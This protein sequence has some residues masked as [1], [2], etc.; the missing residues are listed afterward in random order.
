MTGH[1]I[2]ANSWNGAHVFV[3]FRPSS[4][5]L[6]QN[7]V[8]ENDEGRLFLLSRDF[9]TLGLE[10]GEQSILVRRQRRCLATR[11]DRRESLAWRHQIF[12]LR[13]RDLLQSVKDAGL[14]P[15]C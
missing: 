14:A 10:G 3:G 4:C 7:L 12:G 11:F 9:E 5:H 6:D 1:F 8:V 15:A 13:N 2:G